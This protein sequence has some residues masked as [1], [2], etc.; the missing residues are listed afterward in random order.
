MKKSL[1]FLILL[2][3]VVYLGS[4]LAPPICTGTPVLSFNANAFVR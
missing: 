3:G 2:L 1:P 4:T